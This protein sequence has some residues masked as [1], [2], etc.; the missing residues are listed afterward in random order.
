[1]CHASRVGRS[2]LSPTTFQVL[3]GPSELVFWQHP[4]QL[5]SGEIPAGRPHR[6]AASLARQ[7]DLEQRLHPTTP[8]HANTI[9]WCES[10]KSVARGKGGIYLWDPRRGGRYGSDFWVSL[11]FSGSLISAAR[12]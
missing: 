12:D 4:C 10:E 3:T 11:T 7:T 6:Q 9:A 1:M 5:L 8:T 2:R